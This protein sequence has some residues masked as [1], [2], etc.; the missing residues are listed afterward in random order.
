[1]RGGLPLLVWGVLLGCEAAAPGRADMPGLGSLRAGVAAAIEREGA[2]ADAGDEA[3][4][5]RL[6]PALWGRRPASIREVRLLVDLLGPLGRD[7]L[8]R[9]MARS[10]EYRD[11]WEVL[12]KDHLAVDRVGHISN[13]MC[14]GFRLLPDVGPELAAFVRDAPSDAAGYPALWTFRDLA[15]SALQ[16]DDLSPLWRVHLFA[17]MALEHEIEDTAAARASREAR[18][19]VF[20]GTYL[21]RRL[22]CMGCHNSEF[23]VTGSPDPAQDRTWEIPGLVEKA[24][25]GASDGR[26]VDALRPFFRRH[27]VV[28]G[29]KYFWEEAPAPDIVASFATGSTPWGMDPVCG[30][31]VAP[32]AVVPDDV[33][34]QAFFIAEASDTASVW[35]LEERLRTGFDALRGQPLP[36][37]P[38]QT[39]PGPE[40]FAWMA[41]ASFADFVWEQVMGYRLTIANYFPRN[42]SQ[43]DTLKFTTDRFVGAGYSLQE[44]LVTIA[45]DPLFNPAPPASGGPLRPFAALFDPWVDDGLNGVGDQVQSQAART[46]LRSATLALGWAPIGDFPLYFLSQEAQV[47]RQTG[48]FMKTS[49]RGFRGAGF[50]AALAWESAF[51]TCRDWRSP[52]VC[53][54]DKVLQE[55]QTGESDKCKICANAEKVCAWDPRCCNID[56]L[57][58]CEDHCLEEPANVPAYYLDL[59]RFPRIEVATGTPD[60]VTRILAAAG[61]GATF[62][63]A[64]AAL[65]DRLHTDPELSDP[66]ERALIEALAEVPLD[67]PLKGTADAEDALRLVCGALLSAPQ[68]TLSGWAGPDRIA[69]PEPAITVPETSAA[70]LCETLGRALFGEGAYQCTGSRLIPPASAG[71]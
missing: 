5:K 14:Y 58:V 28:V 26:P 2:P 9:A 25:F 65:K 47:A 45:L 12:I 18:A 15:Y 64:V 10:P 50:Q 60:F 46:L 1:M 23:S 39:V 17:N 41:S 54:V 48:A 24:V 61:P 53:P 6:V 56:W 51:G 8:V 68:F 62:G 30:E 27:G 43:R 4:V 37:A 52:D 29:M 70:A 3:F 71:R 21:Y 49:D 16:L 31:F 13:G 40:A 44:L 34:D 57:A 20:L 33:G 42:R 38:D 35:D 55:A 32:G 69:A 66:D 63:D 22:D 7:G 36:V 67:A 11:H 59:D 19:D